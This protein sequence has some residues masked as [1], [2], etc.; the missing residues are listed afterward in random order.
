MDRLADSVAPHFFVAARPLTVT[1][2]CFTRFVEQLVTTGFFNAG[3]SSQCPI[4]LRAEAVRSS[5]LCR[6]SLLTPTQALWWR[7]KTTALLH[8]KSVALTV[9][10]SW[11]LRQLRANSTKGIAS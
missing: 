5:V 3:A 11:V 9:L 1:H 7:L 4:Y 6:H 10:P 2:N 8:L